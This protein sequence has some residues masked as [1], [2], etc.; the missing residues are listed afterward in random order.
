MNVGTEVHFYFDTE[1]QMFTAII[2]DI[3]HTGNKVFFDSMIYSHHFDKKRDK[4]LHGNNTGMN[5]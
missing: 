4:T 1:M 5:K 2:I 3:V